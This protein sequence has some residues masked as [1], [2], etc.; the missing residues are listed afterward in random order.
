MDFRIIKSP[1]QGVINM[2]K[3]RSMGRNILSDKPYDTIG[4]VQGKLIDMIVASDIA[5]KKSNVEV[6]EIKGL[7][8]QHFAMIGIFGDTS[9]VIEA[10]ESVKENLEQQ[11]SGKFD[12]Y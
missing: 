2:I 9:S 8:P 6:M 11:K 7:C 4:L 3:S 5:E 12:T 10:I 1:S